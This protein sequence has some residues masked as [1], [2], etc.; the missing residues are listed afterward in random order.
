[1]SMKGMLNKTG[2]QTN[3]LPFRDYLN[4][5]LKF[6]FNL[7]EPMRSYIAKENHIGPADI[8]THT[9][10]HPVTFVLGFVTVFSSNFKNKFIRFNF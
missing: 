6:S 3:L 2:G 5:I 9:D 4:N 1:M 8:G 7:W 10:R